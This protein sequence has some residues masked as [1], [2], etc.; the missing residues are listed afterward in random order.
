MALQENVID[1]EDASLLSTEEGRYN[2]FHL[3]LSGEDNSSVS[4]ASPF[5]QVSCFFTLLVKWEIEFIKQE[6]TAQNLK[7]KACT[8]WIDSYFLLDVMVYW[9]ADLIYQTRSTIS[10][11]LISWIGL[12]TCL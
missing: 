1:R 10:E 4:F 2:R 5:G 11:I 6:C 8:A 3:F 12:L 7:Q 9:S